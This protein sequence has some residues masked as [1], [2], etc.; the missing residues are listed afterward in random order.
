MMTIFING[1]EQI[2]RHFITFLEL[3]ELTLEQSSN[4]VDKVRMNNEKLFIVIFTWVLC[5]AIITKCFTGLLLNIYFI[6]RPS[7]TVNSLE[8]LDYNPNINVAGKW[9][10][11]ELKLFDPEYFEILIKRLN[12][13]ENE[14]GFDSLYD[15]LAIFDE[16]LINDIM[17]RR[18]VVLLAEDDAQSY[19]M[20]YPNFKSS[21]NKYSLQY[22]HRYISKNH[23]SYKMIYQA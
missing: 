21:E 11:N 15:P 13:Y 20:I 8:D 16:R 17:N 14:L 19:Q 7:L 1:Q 23:P 3:I 12:A 6:R 5:S 2:K 10:L 22:Y 4:I 9:S 18:A